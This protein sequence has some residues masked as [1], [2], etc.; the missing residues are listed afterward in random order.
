MTDDSKNE[1]RQSEAEA[2][3]GKLKPADMEEA[4]KQ[5][6]K[7]SVMPHHGMASG[8][9]IINVPREPSHPGQ[10][11]FGR[12]F[13]YLSPANH[14]PEFLAW[15]GEKGGPMEEKGG[16]GATPDTSVP[17]GIVFLGQFID[18]DITFDPLSSLS[19][20]NDPEALRNF[21]TPRLDLDSVY[22]MGREGSPFLYKRDDHQ[23]FLTGF[24]DNPD[25]LTRNR[26]Q[27]D[28]AVAL[29]GDPRNDENLLVSQ[30]QY[31]FL[32][33][34]NAVVCHLREGDEDVFN[35]AQQLVRWHYQWII[36]HEFLPAI[37]DEDVVNDVLNE[38][39]YFTIGRE[40]ET[41]LPVEFAGAAYR[42][43]HSMIRQ[44]YRVNEQSGSLPLF[45]GKSG[46]PS[47]GM[48][49][50]P[51]PSEL[52]VEWKY[53]FAL[54][55]DIEAQHARPIDTKLMPELFDLPFVEESMPDFIR[56]L[57][58]RNLVR[59][60]RLDLPSGQSVARAMGEN[61]LSNE[62]IGFANV[63]EEYN[64]R[65]DS[66]DTISEDTEAPL[67]Y[68]VLAEAEETANGDH[69]GPVGSRIVAEVLVGLIEADPSSFHT[70]QPKWT[71]TLPAPSSGSG[72]YTMADLLTF[73]L[74]Q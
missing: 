1:K 8:R 43:G 65:L 72:S 34:H 61:A 11:R 22:G 2:N 20:Q 3:G 26:D 15:L 42:F 32:R 51:V 35:E 69:L 52:A 48:G 12:M 33:F 56:S 63:I 36:L 73:A 23:L 30:L 31:A 70:M 62:E 4:L 74:G 17:S 71:P 18:H 38:R 46:D 59:G 67:W 49:F 68:Y 40:D 29:I 39:K 57:A 13:P 45:A 7:P 41:Y 16:D 24:K 54:D 64:A 66:T 21:R 27:D 19:R 37:C 25:D 14:S 58:A 55:D 47:L 5:A 53:F 60:L 28:K 9:G 44:K 10:G 50:Q 6:T